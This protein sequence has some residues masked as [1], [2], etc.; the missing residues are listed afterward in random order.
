MTDHR[1]LNPKVAYLKI[2]VQLLIYI[3]T[4]AA[5]GSL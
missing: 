5:K 4:T 2:F 1:L 3:D